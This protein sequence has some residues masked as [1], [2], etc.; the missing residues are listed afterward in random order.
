MTEELDALKKVEDV[1]ECIK[2]LATSNDPTTLDAADKL[3][4]KLE[5]GSED[6]R[7]KTN[8][9]VITKD[10]SNGNASANAAESAA[11]MREIERDAAERADRRERNRRRAAEWKDRGNAQFKLANYDQAVDCYTRGLAIAKDFELLYQNRANC[12][13]KQGRFEEALAD[14]EAAIF[15]TREKCAKPFFHQAKALTG[16]NRLSEAR[17]A[18]SRMSSCSDAAPGH[19]DRCLADLDRLSAARKAEARA[20]EE[21]SSG[22]G[23]SV[24]M[25]IYRLARGDQPTAYYAAGMRC[26]AALLV[27][28]NERALFRAKS[29]F[30]LLNKQQVVVTTLAVPLESMT[31]AQLDLLT[32]S[33]T[34]AAAVAK[35]DSENCHQLA[36]L[37][38]PG[39][40]AARAVDVV[41]F[42]GAS[43]SASDARQA[44]LDALSKIG[45]LACD[46]LCG[47]CAEPAGLVAALLRQTQRL[48]AQTA[49]AA[50]HLF[51]QL[52]GCVRL[53]ERLERA[54]PNALAGIAQAGES[55]VSAGASE[56]LAAFCLAVE[57]L[58]R[59]MAGC[60]P[61]RQA[62]AA[63]RA[64]MTACCT[65]LERYAPDKEEDCGGEL[66]Q[67]AAA[68]VAALLASASLEAT[69]AVSGAAVRLGEMALRLASRPSVAPQ[70]REFS[71]ALLATLAPRSV[72]LAR[73]IGAG[74]W[75]PSLLG[76]SA[77]V[78]AS[79]D[80]P[81]AASVLRVLAAVLAAQPEARGQVGDDP[82]WLEL[83]LELL[84]SR[85][86]C[87]LGNA[88]LCLSHCIEDTAAAELLAR[89]D[90]V[91]L[92]LCRMRD[93][94]EREAKANCAILCG[95]LAQ[96]HHGHR[97][98]LGQLDGIN[99]LNSVITCNN[100]KL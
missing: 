23:N 70:L 37:S 44:A 61:L 5:D 35:E 25:L 21:F 13:V 79:P 84:H 48:A 56:S 66:Q 1:S 28:A 2:Q 72:E 16:L 55:L 41:A 91:R 18:Y 90:I 92:L 30:S 43:P 53:R 96:A 39:Q 49:L 36:Q 94:R 67:S 27:G 98:R 50:A 46:R 82:Q 47:C 88:A 4:K 60:R 40:L 9:T 78:L 12:Y 59:L 89:T 80:H 42:N 99:I 8:R 11:F 15:L 68:E 75:A 45:Q 17:E 64:F 58:R 6:L 20:L 7:T 87:L 22:G 33:L 74:S 19:A 97:E 76:L 77:R 73:Q 14:A 83:L 93:C 95:K 62:A 32:A 71:L 29:G 24:E 85:A 26:L 54:A 57:A 81:C 34:L 3:L 63:R 69:P 31:D 51:S 100:I 52:A 65:A 38:K 10:S 86:D